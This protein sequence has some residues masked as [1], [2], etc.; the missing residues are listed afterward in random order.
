MKNEERK[1][2]DGKKLYEPPQLKKIHLY[3]QEAVLDC[4]LSGSGR[5]VGGNCVALTCVTIS[6][7]DTPIR[8]NL[9]DRITPSRPTRPLNGHRDAT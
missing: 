1:V 7:C 4:R 5:T 2:M 8:R 6:S 3:P 9:A